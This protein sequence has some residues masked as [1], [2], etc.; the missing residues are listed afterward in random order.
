MNSE[1]N[2]RKYEN[3]L[4]KVMQNSSQII[5]N[6]CENFQKQNYFSQ[7]ANTKK[8]L[9]SRINHFYWSLPEIVMKFELEFE[10]KFGPEFE[11]E[12]DSQKNYCLSCF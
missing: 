5:R 1:K 4:R 3:I 8:I 6:L 12:H 11:L 10:L 9:P 7:T 2:I